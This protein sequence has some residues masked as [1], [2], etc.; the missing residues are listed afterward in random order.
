[1]NDADP[2]MKVKIIGPWVVW[3]TRKGY[4]WSAGIELRRQNWRTEWTIQK[5]VLSALGRFGDS[6]VVYQL[7]R[8]KFRKEKFD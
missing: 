2:Q 7:T 3:W 8:S 6:S 5:T 4:G 1:M